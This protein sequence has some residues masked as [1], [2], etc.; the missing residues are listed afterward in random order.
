MPQRGLRPRAAGGPSGTWAAAHRAGRPPRA[1]A[2]VAYGQE[3]PPSDF[4]H[5]GTGRKNGKSQHLRVLR[6][7]CMSGPSAGVYM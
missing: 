4:F 7:N 2:P 5:A 3:T 1:G 6:P